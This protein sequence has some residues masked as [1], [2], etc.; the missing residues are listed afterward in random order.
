MM[1]FTWEAVGADCQRLCTA[2]A[3]PAYDRQLLH[4]RGEPASDLD[5][6]RPACYQLDKAEAHARRRSSTPP[7]RTAAHGADMLPLK[8]IQIACDAAKFGVALAGVRRQVRGRQASLAELRERIRKTV[9]F[10]APVPRRGY[11]GHGT[12]DITVPAPR[13]QRRAQG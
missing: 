9:E 6:L 13:Q 7:C 4:S 5:V 3:R 10:I 8:Q 12:R 11:R 1:M 2:E